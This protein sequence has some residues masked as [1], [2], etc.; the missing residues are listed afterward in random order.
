MLTPAEP[1][2][3]P[4]RLTGMRATRAVTAAAVACVA[5]VS[6]CTTT[7][8]TTTTSQPPPAIVPTG[9]ALSAA[10]AMPS[11]YVVVTGL[12][13]VVRASGD[14]RVTGSVRVPGVPGNARFDVTVE[15][16]GGADDRHFVLL[17]SRGGD[18]PGVSDVT[19]YLLTVSSA[20]R[21][22]RLRQ[23]NFDNKSEPVIGAALSPDGTMLALSLAWEFLPPVYGQVVLLNVQTGTMRTWTARAAPG[24]WPGVPAW[25]G[26]GQVLV[27]WWHGTSQGMNPAGITGVREL[28][29]AAPGRSLLGAPLV[30]F[31]VPVTGLESAM[32]APGGGDVIVSSCRAGH[33]TATARVSE[34]STSD[35]RLVQVLRT[36]TAR[37]R[38]DADAEDAV[39]AEC[40]VLSVAGAADVLVQAFA[41]GRIDN[42]TFTALPGTSPDVLPVSAAW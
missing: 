41:L 40:Q 9:A 1:R 6:A 20:G 15:A 34:L 11:Y 31:A 23:L 13:V 22:G 19:V 8:T 7:T 28:D 33:H 37:F 29:I 5:A 2:R 12:D 4:V 10:G 21:P 18:L 36:Q 27:P 14:G 35:G 30:T 24:Y 3:P 16:F 32:I 17:V 26:D 25:A 42:G 38:N 39:F